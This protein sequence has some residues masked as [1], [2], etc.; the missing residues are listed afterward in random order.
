MVSLLHGKPK[1]HC[2][3]MLPKV[4]EKIYLTLEGGINFCDN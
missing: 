4:L 2:D 3:C 1:R